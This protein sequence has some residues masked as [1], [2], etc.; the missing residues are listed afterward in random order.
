MQQ[1]WY[2]LRYLPSYSF[3]IIALLSIHFQILNYYLLVITSFG[4][5]PF[6]ELFLNNKLE[7]AQRMATKPYDLLL[8][9][10]V[11]FHY[12][13][14]FFVLFTISRHSFSTLEFFGM[15]STL[16]ILC[17]VYG[18]NAA[19]ELGHRSSGFEQFLAKTLLLSSLYMHFYIEHN[20][21]HHKKVGTLQDP[22][23]AR[24]NE[25][26][27][28][29]WIRCIK[30]SYT[31]AFLLEK[32]RL[33]RKGE[34]W[35]S[36]HN[37]FLAFQL[38]QIIF[39]LLVYFVFGLQALILFITAAAV[40]ILLL[41]TINYVEHYGLKRKIIKAGIPERVQAMHSWN[42]DRPLGRYLL[43]ELTRHSDHHDNSSVKY[44]NLKSR[45][46]APQLPAGYPA[47]MILAMVPFL[48]K[49]V[50]NKRLI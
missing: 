3:G 29:F 13:M 24:M 38:I 40:G 11:P 32:D 26:L 39:I 41:E 22:A 31:S 17:G 12:S 5:I 28:R 47:M 7:Y 45:S 44:P 25:S 23:T 50:M 43:F 18:I 36:K 33:V 19:H 46:S 37:S 49:R 6:L 8:Y 34:K 48:W 42:S 20:R 2:F 10:I 30:D 1:K 14:L 4:I 21:G 9:F 16:G 15:A 27:Y 35:F